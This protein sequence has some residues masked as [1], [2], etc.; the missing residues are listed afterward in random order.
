MELEF[1]ADIERAQRVGS[2]DYIIPASRLRPYLVEALE[3][4]IAREMEHLAR[5]MFI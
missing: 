2:V 5:Q 1:G 4:G 3:R